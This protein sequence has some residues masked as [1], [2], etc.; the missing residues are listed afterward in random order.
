MKCVRCGL[1]K[2]GIDDGTYVCDDCVFFSPI[3]EEVFRDAQS[4]LE[5][6]ATID[7]NSS[8]IF[9]LLADSTFISAMNPTTRIY[10][11][12]CEYLV[13]RAVK[14]AVE[15]TEEDLNRHIRTTRTWTAIFN[16]LSDLG[17]VQVRARKHQRV[18]VLTDLML[19]MGGPFLDGRPVSE[20]VA[21][22]LAHAY[23]GYVLL[24]VLT[25]VA[26]IKNEDDVV[27]LPYKQRP[28]APWVIL[29]YLWKTA[30]SGETTF[31]DEELRKFLARR[32]LSV[33]V[34]GR[35]V[36]SLRGF[37]G[38]TSQA[39][40]RKADDTADVVVFEFE[41]YAMQEMQRIRELIRERSR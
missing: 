38:K 10:Y 18:L 24:F 39:L 36:R 21:L 29:M 34:T 16:V 33:A 17:L 15:V 35:I 30:S 9:R 7:P 4:E 41:E 40:I 27:H 6:V 5:S 31:N 22:R 20:Q 26:R 1:Q 23:A 37:D 28:K 3:V 19:R 13:E 8:P 12:M 2:S 14:G 25:K 11:R 32:G